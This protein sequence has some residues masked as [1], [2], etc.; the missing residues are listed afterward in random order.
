MNSIRALIDEDPSR[1]REAVTGLSN[2]LRSS[3]SSDQHETITLERELNIVKDYLALELIR[4]ED[5]LNVQYGIDDDTLDHQ[6]PPMMLQTLV[7]NAIKHGIGKTMHKGEISILA[8][9]TNG[10]LVL[11]VINTGLLD[12]QPD[13][14]GFGLQSTSNRLLLI[15]GDAASF[16]IEQLN[17]DMVEAKVII[18]LS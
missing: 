16:S 17:K 10:Q 11:S 8:S 4:F 6:V 15:F 13:H 2:I 14:E 12:I 7:E 3:M 1:A 5:R 18:P 9:E